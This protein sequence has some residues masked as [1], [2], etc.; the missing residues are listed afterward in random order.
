MPAFNLAAILELRT[1]AL[2]RFFSTFPSGLPGVGL[3]I[4][5]LATGSL[6][7]THGVAHGAPVRKAEVLFPVVEI[8]AGALLLA[9]F[10]TP[11][12][13][14]ALAITS[15]GIAFSWIAPA[16]AAIDSF[17]YS[18]F[19]AAIAAAITLLGPGW[20]SIDARLFGRHRII[21]PTTRKLDR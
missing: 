20:L 11:F 2:R 21:I 7:I 5:R 14:A 12:A 9:G 3:L 4:L 16:P 18:L 15:S 13:G 10:L 1:W 8:G 19:V 6:A 17:S